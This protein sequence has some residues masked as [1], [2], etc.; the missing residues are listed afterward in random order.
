MRVS[1]SSFLCYCLWGRREREKKEKIVSMAKKEKGHSGSNKGSA[2]FKALDE[3][4]DWLGDRSPVGLGV[5]AEVIPF[6]VEVM[7]SSDEV[8]VREAEVK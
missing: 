6:I 8:E 3:V 5:G 1:L 4:W 2:N 7:S